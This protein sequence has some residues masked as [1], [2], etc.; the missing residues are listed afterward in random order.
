MELAFKP[1]SLHVFSVYLEHGRKGRINEKLHEETNLSASN[2]YSDFLK[3]LGSYV[4]I[5]GKSF[6]ISVSLERINFL[7]RSLIWPP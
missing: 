2:W 5:Q 1:A 7:P 6:D 4:C 3:S